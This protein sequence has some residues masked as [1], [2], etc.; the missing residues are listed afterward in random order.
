[1]NSFGARDKGKESGNGEKRVKNLRRN[2][3][4]I[5]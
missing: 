4:E 2:R 3:F 5:A 1:M